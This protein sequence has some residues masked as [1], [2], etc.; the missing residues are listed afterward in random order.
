M[1]EDLNKRVT[2]LE[3]RVARLER[4]DLVITAGLSKKDVKKLLS[5]FET[6]LRKELGGED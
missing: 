1:A 3:E 4:R 6:K 2:D 5:E